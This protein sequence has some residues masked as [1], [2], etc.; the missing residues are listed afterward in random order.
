MKKLQVV[1]S[2]MLL[3]IFWGCGGSSDEAKSLLTHNLKLVGIPQEIVV[4]ICQDTNDNG[5]CDENE[6][7]AKIKVNR[8]DSVA[9]MWKKI[10]FDPEGRYILEN[11]DPTKSIIMELED[12]ENL[13]HD[14]HRLGLRYNP[15]T[16]EL[17]VLQALVDADLL[18]EEDTKDLKALENRDEIDTILLDSLRVNQ[19][20]LKDE[21]LSTK[22]ALALNLGEIAK[23]LIN[24]DIAK[25]LP[26][27]IN[28]CNND[29]SCIQEILAVASDKVELTKAE[30]Q[31]LARSKRIVDAYIIKLL[32]PVEAICANGETYKSEL[33]VG[34]HGRVDFK[35]FPVGKECN[36]TVARGATI[37]SNNNGKLDEEDKLLSFEM[38]GSADATH[39]TPLSTLLFQKRLNNEPS[40][41]FA[42]MIQNFD[43]VTAPNRVISNRGIEK[44]KIEKLIVLS[45]IAKSSMKEFADIS[46]IDLSEIITTKSN[47]TL[48]DLD[49]EKLIKK[50]PENIKNRVREKATKAKKLVLMLQ[51]LDPFK[52]SF[53]DF[54][55]AFSDGEK[56]IEEALRQSLLISLPNGVDLLDFII[57]SKIVASED[58][59]SNQELRSQIKESIKEEIASINILPTAKA[60]SDTTITQENS[61]SLNALNSEDKDGTITSY[62]WWSN[63]KL[64]E[65]E[66]TITLDNLSVGLHVITLIVTDNEGGMGS[67]SL[68]IT[69]EPIQEI[70]IGDENSTTPTDE[71]STI[72]EDENV[73]IPSD[74][75]LTTP[76]QD[77][78]TSQ[79]IAVE[80]QT[81]IANAGA[82]Q[83]ITEGSSVVLNGSNSLDNDG[84]I[85]SYEWK[86]NGETISY[87]MVFNYSNMIIGTNTFTLIVTD[88]KGKTSSDEITVT[89][90]KTTA[91]PLPPSSPPKTEKHVAD[92]YLIKIDTPAV[93]Y[94]PNKEYTSSLTIGAKG[95]ILFSNV[96]L[97]NN[98]HIFISEGATIDS[99]N[100]GVLDVNDTVLN[101]SMKGSSSG[102]F[103]SPLTT[104]LVEKEAKGEDVSAFKAMVQDF[105]PVTCASEIANGTGIEKVKNQKL[106]LLMEVV[107]TTLTQSP[108]ANISD[109][110]IS[111]I[112]STDLNESID[113]LNIT[114]LGESFSSE[115]QTLISIKSN[116]IRKLINT[117]DDLD[118]SKIDINSLY[119]N[120]SDGNQSVEN[121]ILLSAKVTINTGDNLLEIIAKADANMSAIY[122]NFLAMNTGSLYSMTKP[123]AKAGADITIMEGLDI[124][125]S[126]MGSFDADGYIYSYSW[127][128]GEQNLST[129]ISFVKDNFSVGEH[130]ITLT[131]T[132]DQNETDSDLVM[133]T[134]LKDLNRTAIQAVEEFVQMV[135]DESDVDDAPLLQNSNIVFNDVLDSGISDNNISN[136]NSDNNLT[137]ERLSVLGTSIMGTPVTMNLDVARI[138]FI[139]SIDASYYILSLERNNTSII[140]PENLLLY[141]ASDTGIISNDP[142]SSNNLIFTPDDIDSQTPVEI[143][144]LESKPLD[145]FTITPVDKLEYIGISNTITLRDNVPPTTVLQSYY[146]VDS[147]TSNTTPILYVASKLLDNLDANGTEVT[148]IIPSDNSLLKELYAL[149]TSYDDNGTTTQFT[150]MYDTVAFPAMSKTRTVDVTFSEE[151]NLIVTP[152]V[153]NGTSMLSG[154]TT[155]TNSTDIVK[156]TVDD[157]INLA[158]NDHGAV[159]DFTGISDLAGNV[160]SVEANAKVVIL[161]AMPPF[162]TKASFT[163]ETVDITFNEAVMLTAD[164]NIT[165]DGNLTATYTTASSAN[166]TLSTDSKTLTVAVSEFTNPADASESLQRSRFNLGRYIETAYD[167][168]ER[169]HSRMTWSIKDTQGNSW[170][171]DNN[172]TAP[173]FAIVDLIGDFQVTTDNSLFKL[174]DDTT[175]VDQ[176]VKW[177]FNHPIQTGAG[178]DLMSNNA[179]TDVIAHMEAVVGATEEN[180][181][182]QT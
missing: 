8:G 170:A 86:K 41:E 93:A 164:A 54:F 85:V 71:N 180:L 109:I 63:E 75:N 50:L 59:V 67:D 160:A 107:K 100:N 16:I 108:D 9:Q 159:I 122:Q 38:V 57:K 132:D 7:Q 176:V 179:T 21:N 178:T 79:E 52:V 145:I 64:L 32:K 125:L 44:V 174:S 2:S 171:T 61:V 177:T 140:L 117:F 34:E 18:Q 42:N 47:S 83:N 94:C 135:T 24:I 28:A 40:K 17:S 35:S 55:V 165:I 153:T 98:C 22:N 78:N 37:D 31:E 87:S 155:D 58:E 148:D 106:M 119:I 144:I 163:P 81:P 80:N 168:Y 91:E 101:F 143:V 181:Q 29:K 118:P 128:E 11:Y 25:D 136:M 146:R 26:A 77:E 142:N 45:E 167:S 150:T 139:P 162:V 111:S 14:D 72:P 149:N 20:L 4:N 99:N 3:S 90:N 97:P 88:D 70:P 152:T 68:L 15:D 127:K 65:S 82:D 95:K 182:K 30:A 130:N 5:F 51:D 138:S 123:V 76:T 158:N 74:E 120:I 166:Y 1:I 6:L 56:G 104:M 13:T 126:A 173:A 27:Q 46:K 62:Q 48:E 89:V 169:Y 151:I 129:N 131:V 10:R 114:Q 121:A 92:G 157:V 102:S 112:V 66:A 124:N 115:I 133:I 39:I 172:I 43:P 147:N 73:T 49:I 137:R 175:A 156:F 110:N 161:D 23:G 36:I 116:K 103:I 141:G 154:W 19:N 134:I 33:A 96:A 113:E 69:V 105:D 12:R 60:G 84:T 53:N